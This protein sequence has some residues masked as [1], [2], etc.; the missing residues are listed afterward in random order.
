M[1]ARLFRELR[2]SVLLEKDLVVDLLVCVVTNLV[3]ELSFGPSVGVVRGP[4]EMA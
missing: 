4:A 1:V 2:F 3:N